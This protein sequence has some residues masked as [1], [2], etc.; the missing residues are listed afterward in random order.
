MSNHIIISTFDG[1]P[2]EVIEKPEL[3]APILFKYKDVVSSELE[4]KVDHNSQD[5]LKISF[6]DYVKN[7]NINE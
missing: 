5:M 7:F 4:L 6:G 1:H 3:I 2:P